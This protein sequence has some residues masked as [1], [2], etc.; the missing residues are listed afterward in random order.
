MIKRDYW[1]NKIKTAWEKRSLVWLSGVRRVGKTTLAKEIDG[2]LLLNCDLPSTKETLNNPEFFFKNLS[3]PVVIF[4][5]IHQLS[6]PSNLLKIG[7]DS[8]PHVK[9]LA[10]GSSTLAA[11]RKFRD[12]LA[13]RKYTVHLMP[14]LI[15]ECH[16]FGVVDIKKRLL[17]GGLPEMLLSEKRETVFYSEWLDSFY[18]RD[19]HEL[20]RVDKRYGFLTL[21]EFVM[22]LSGSLLDVTSLSKHCGLSRPTVM[23]YLEILQETHV[24][25]LLRPFHGGSRRELVRQP[26]AYSF[27]TGFSAFYRGW[28]DLREEDC[29]SLWEQLVFDFL[30]A[31]YNLRQLYF[32]RDKDKR[33]IDFI[34]SFDRDNVHA[35][36]CKWNPAAFDITAVK[37]FRQD[38][39][40]GLNVVLS[41]QVE[42]SYRKQ[43]GANEIIFANTKDLLTI[44]TP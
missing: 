11:T 43:Y 5:E 17:Y 12:S 7:T 4:D 9:I 10:T 16:D 6:D 26:K 22:R 2:T 20:F 42:A 14:A 29:G 36:E 8:F 37:T 18:A 19:V 30:A 28:S 33:E 44:I 27:D 40:K 41:P 3:Y 25:S 21:T 34:Y 24:L 39:P 32:W 23:N 1:L 13:G 38:Y 15:S 35:I 31:N